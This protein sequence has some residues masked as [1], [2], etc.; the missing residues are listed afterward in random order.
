MTVIILDAMVKI[1]NSLTLTYEVSEGSN[2]RVAVFIATQNNATQPN[3]TSITLDGQSATEDATVDEPIANTQS[4]IWSVLE[5]DISTGAG[6]TCTIAGTNIDTSETSI[7]LVV[8]QDCEQVAPEDTDVVAANPATS[9]TRTLA[10][11]GGSMLL[12]SLQKRNTNDVTAGANQTEIL[13]LVY[14]GEGH[15]VSHQNGDDGGVMSASW[16]GSVSSA[17]VVVSYPSVVSAY[18][19]K[20]VLL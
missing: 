9:A 17:Y 8:L 19:P 7:G 3:I 6:L 14:S 2:R 5:T 4:G 11:A 1:S 12:D 13:D 10:T 15:F 20:A 16:S 18:I